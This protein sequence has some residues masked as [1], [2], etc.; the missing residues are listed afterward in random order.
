MFI[1]ITMA[2]EKWRGGG[3]EWILIVLEFTTA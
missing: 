1:N 3:L 2:K